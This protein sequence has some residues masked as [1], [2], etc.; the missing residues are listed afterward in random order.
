M[1]MYRLRNRFHGLYTDY[2]SD[3]CKILIAQV[4]SV[5][6]GTALYILF[7]FCYPWIKFWT[8]SIT[9]FAS[10]QA[11]SSLCT[12][13][14]QSITML[15]ILFFGYIRRKK[16]TES[17]INNNRVEER[18]AYISFFDPIVEYYTN[19][20]SKDPRKSHRVNVTI[21]SNF[22]NMTET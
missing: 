13:F 19:H 6:I 9:R 21:D 4:L 1:L 12:F 2:G 5:F 22:E 8:E 10:L 3:L 15:S 7:Y 20:G 17:Q 16:V 11:I 14:V 18:P